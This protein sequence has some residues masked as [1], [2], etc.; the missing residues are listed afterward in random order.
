[1]KPERGLRSWSRTARLRRGTESS[2]RGPF[3][4]LR[5]F[6][7][8]PGR[9]EDLSL[10]MGRRGTLA[11]SSSRSARPFPTL[12]LPGA[13]LALS[14]PQPHPGTAP[15]QAPA[16]AVWTWVLSTA[17]ASS[18]VVSH[19]TLSPEAPSA[20]KQKADLFYPS[21]QQFGRPG[22]SR[23]HKC[24]RRSLWHQP[25]WVLEPVSGR[26]WSQVGAA[27]L[28]QGPPAARDARRG[29]GRSAQTGWGQTLSCRPTALG[30]KLS[31]APAL[32][33]STEHHS[34]HGN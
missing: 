3:A 11:I 14:I 10:P 26:S 17:R 1:M 29:T 27:D 12:G 24:T 22:L 8:A 6:I 19:H 2:H 4:T 5:L 21:T 20:G 9:G 32:C 15:G 13:P 28:A 33:A 25:R 31:R 23:S 7:W 30:L 16:G 34:R 18:D